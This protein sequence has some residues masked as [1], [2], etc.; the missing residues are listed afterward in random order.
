MQM[1]QRK[2][3]DKDST[4]GSELWY[5]LGAGDGAEI[6]DVVMPRPGPLWSMLESGASK[7][8]D[9]AVGPK[10]GGDGGREV[11]AAFSGEMGVGTW[12]E[13]EAEPKLLGFG[14]A[15]SG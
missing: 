2:T 3:S 12:L 6:G 9:E 7:S 13:A 4:A 1:K 5:E 10:T 14:M 15:K 11:E 8:L